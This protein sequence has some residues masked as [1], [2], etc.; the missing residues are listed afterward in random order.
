MKTVKKY[1]TI[2][3]DAVSE[4]LWR[5]LEIHMIKIVLFAALMLAVYDVSL[6]MM[7]FTTLFDC[8]I[9]C[10]LSCLGLCRSC[11]LRLAGYRCTSLSTRSALRFSLLCHLVVCLVALQDDISD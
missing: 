11:D 6:H 8:I 3:F 2:I 7:Q 9:A 1:A 10:S 5:F 4:F